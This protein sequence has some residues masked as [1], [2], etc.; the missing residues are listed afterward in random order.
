MNKEFVIPFMLS[1]LAGLGTVVGGLFSFFKYKKREE[2]ISFCLSFS[3]SAM[4]TL[5]LVEL[6]PG[7]AKV[8]FIRYGYY[9][10]L[11]IILIILFLS[12]LLIK[13]ISKKSPLLQKDGLYRVGVLSMITIILHN[14]PEGIATFMS[15]YANINDGIKLSIAILIHN[16]PEGISAAVPLALSEQSNKRGVVYSIICA[17]SEPLGA[18]VGYIL[19]KDY[20]NEFVLSIVLLFVSGLMISLSIEELIP[21]IVLYNNKKNSI[22][23][24]VVGFIIVIISLILL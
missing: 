22:Y 10:S 19:L 14:F 24:F 23:G 17:L 20:L 4:T 6:I 2:F 5:S 12:Y 21:E 7:S 11:L 8:L 13:A 1:L 3:A 15:S 16:I 9:I 18:I